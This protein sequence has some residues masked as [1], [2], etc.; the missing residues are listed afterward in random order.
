ML[1][2]LW[3]ESFRHLTNES[4]KYSMIHDKKPKYISWVR[5]KLEYDG[6]TILDPP[7]PPQAVNRSG[8]LE[9]IKNRT[10]FFILFPFLFI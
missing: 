8:R 1:I 10:N 2:N 4:G 5:D 9:I 7:A 6:I 3:D